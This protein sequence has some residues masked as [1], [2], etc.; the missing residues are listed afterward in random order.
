MLTKEALLRFIQAGIS[1]MEKSANTPDLPVLIVHAQ[2]YEF[3]KRFCS[4]EDS[5]LK[6]QGVEILGYDGGGILK[7][8]KEAE[9]VLDKEPFACTDPPL[10]DA[11]STGDWDL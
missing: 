4:Q 9:P 3:M 8:L 6:F 7:I 1:D 10:V 2:D 5:S 11:L